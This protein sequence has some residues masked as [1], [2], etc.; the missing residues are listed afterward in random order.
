MKSLRL[1]F[2]HHSPDYQWWYGQ[3]ALDGDLL[4]VK[5]AA[6][7]LRRQKNMDGDRRPLTGRP[8]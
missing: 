8:E 6:S 4:R 3:A 2:A 7:R 5:A 1:G